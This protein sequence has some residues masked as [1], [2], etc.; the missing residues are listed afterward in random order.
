MMSAPDP[1][2]TPFSLNLLQLVRHILYIT[3]NIYSIASSP[4]KVKSLWL[5]PLAPS[6]LLLA[7]MVNILKDAQHSESVHQITAGI[8]PH[9]PLQHHL[10][11]DSWMIM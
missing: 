11:L 6:D 2:S 7:L 9:R 10:R 8:E 3:K 5:K 1:H 4:M